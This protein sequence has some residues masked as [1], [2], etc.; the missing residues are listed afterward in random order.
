MAIAKALGKAHDGVRIKDA[1]LGL[2]VV[3]PEKSERTTTT[4]R[5]THLCVKDQRRN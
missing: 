3:H 1:G 2:V 5:L 4:N